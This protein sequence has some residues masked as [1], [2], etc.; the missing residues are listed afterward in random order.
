M[1]DARGEVLASSSIKTKKHSDFN[2][3]LDELHAEVTRMLT[4]NDAEDKILG[5]SSVCP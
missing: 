3:Y 5:S 4:D 1:V 2:D